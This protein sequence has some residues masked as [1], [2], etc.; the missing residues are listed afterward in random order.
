MP[1]KRPILALT[2]VVLALAVPTTAAALPQI[3]AHRGPV[4]GDYVRRAHDMGLEVAPF[5]LDAAADVRAARSAGVDV[6]ITDD[7][8]MAARALG[9]RPARF[10]SAGA[11]ILGNRLFATGDLLTPRGV[12]ARQGCRGTVTMRVMIGRRPT[13]TV[14][15]RLN[16]NC[17]FRFS[18]RRTPPRLGAP[19]VTVRFN[20]NARVLPQLDGPERAGLAAPVFRP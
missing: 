1:G 14:R 9:M 13:R 17:E 8:L 3:H 16:R 4:T 20:G 19:T 12:S 5:T 2:A 15:G 18:T 6:V 11:F 7:A 10:F